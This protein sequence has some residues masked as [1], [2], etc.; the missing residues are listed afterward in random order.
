M[1]VR[2]YD[3]FLLP[4]SKSVQGQTLAGNPWFLL[5]VP[6]PIIDFPRFRRASLVSNY[7]YQRGGSG[8]LT[9]TKMATCVNGRAC[10][11]KSQG[12][13]ESR[14]EHEFYRFAP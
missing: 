12:R 7:T 14:R 1:K 5:P 13:S 10:N 8:G 9:K 6:Q 4:G 3:R 2:I 11:S